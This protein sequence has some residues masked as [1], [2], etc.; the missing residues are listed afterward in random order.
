MP[1]TT[2]YIDESERR[3]TE[4]TYVTSVLG[5]LWKSDVAVTADPVVYQD[6]S[7]G[8]LFIGGEAVS[9][10]TYNVWADP[11]ADVPSQY[12]I[13]TT[14]ENT[15][16]VEGFCWV[17][18][19][20][21][22]TVQIRTQLTKVELN[23]TTTEFMLSSNPS[24]LYSGDSGEHLISVGV[25]DDPAW[26]LVRSIPLQIP[27]DEEQYSIG[28]VIE[29]TFEDPSN[30]GDINISRPTII[31]TH[32][33][34]DSRMVTEVATFLP[35]VFLLKD[36]AQFDENK[37]TY[38][39]MRLIDVS[40]N[41]ANDVFI[42]V[43]Q[44]E[45]LDIESGF[46]STDSGTYSTLVSPL[47]ADVDTLRWLSQFRGRNLV[48]TYEP[49]TE[50]EEWEQFILDFSTLDGT[51]V[52]ATSAISTSGV[53]GGVEEYFRWQVETGYYGH[54]AGTIDGMLSAIQLF[55]SGDKY[56][57]YTVTANSIHFQTSIDETFG[58]DALGVGDS[59]PYIIQVVE[60]TRPLG[61]IV[62]HELVA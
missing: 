10:T 1:S 62:T 48:V 26:H 4:Q 49:S 12:A 46:E 22:C 17:R 21:N 58:A 59:S 36:S 38:P 29:V 30:P 39:L 56:I 8:S 55:L 27:D 51:D 32:A 23:P 18:P 13:T 3:F 50:G 7:Y 43:E 34:Y 47:Y 52:L 9:E 5:D 53:S 41:T 54:N 20:K 16:Y 28:L 2:N 15:D 57:N 60:P 61:M 35:E 14:T 19:T 37:V 24:D 6:A 42:K 31:R 25:A 11:L 40:T 45:Y 33:L 44:I